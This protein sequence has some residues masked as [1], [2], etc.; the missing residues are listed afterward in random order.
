MI[1]LCVSSLFCHFNDSLLFF[2]QVKH[3]VRIPAIHRMVWLHRWSS[4]TIRETTWPSSAGRA[5]SSTVRTV[6]PR[7]VPAVRPRVIG[8]GRCR[9][10]E[11]TKRFK[12][13]AR[14]QARKITGI[15]RSITISQAAPTL[16]LI[17]RSLTTCVCVRESDSKDKGWC[18]IAIVL[19]REKLP[20][21]YRR[22]TREPLLPL[23][24]KQRRR[25][26]HWRSVDL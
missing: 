25:H 18:V 1:D 15:S 13:K 11:A 16:P 26:T 14:K 20:N 12:R 24:S 19:K 3:N 5:S 17:E 4:T 7:N 9:S 10:V 6:A 23:C 21:N 8:P 2:P 22:T